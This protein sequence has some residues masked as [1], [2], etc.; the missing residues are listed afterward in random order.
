MS[1]VKFLPA[2]FHAIADYAVGLA[3]VLV[4]VTVDMSTEATVAG[5]VVGVT[6][7]AVSMLTRYPLGVVKVLPFTL[8]SAGDYAAALLLFVAPFALGFNDTDSGVT[9][10]YIVVGAAVAAVSLVTN[11]QYAPVSSAPVPAP[12]AE[13]APVRPIRS[14]TATKKA[15]ARKA[16]ATSKKAAPARVT[17]RTASA[18]PKARAAAK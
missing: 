6:V 1:A 16:A 7:L 17:A 14:A 18:K 2:W 5:V 8:H 11:Y 12:A 4:A 10:F 9:V 3:L 13:V 15:P